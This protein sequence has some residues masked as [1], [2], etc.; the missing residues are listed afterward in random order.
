[1]YAV[2]KGKKVGIF[3]TWVACQEQVVGFKGAK[4]K[5]FTDAKEANRFIKNGG[6]SA[7]KKKSDK[8]VRKLGRGAPVARFECVV[9]TDGSCLNNGMSV[10]KPVGG[11]G[12]YCPTDENLNL[13]EPLHD[14]NPT[15]QKAELVAATEAL[16]L[17]RKHLYMEF[18]IHTDSNYV[19]TCSKNGHSWRENGWKRKDG[20]PTAN[21]AYVAAFL[22]ALDHFESKCY[23]IAYIPAHRGFAGNE[24]ADK[25][26]N[27][28]AAKS[29]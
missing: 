3:P 1:M 12:V 21:Q 11:I 22:D 2:A 7:V 4:F 19:I 16:V 9:Y 25:F 6:I 24:M 20:A 10:R 17:L 8:K 13:A 23:R 27:E 26:A 28:G 18:E 5:K 29:K 14:P 15:N